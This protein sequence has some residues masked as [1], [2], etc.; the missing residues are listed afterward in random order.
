MDKTKNRL[1][2]IEGQIKGIQKMYD[3]KRGCLDI[4]QQVV[5]VRQALGR[6]GKD[7]LAGEAVACSKNVDKKEEF[8]ELIRKLFDLT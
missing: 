3:E 7:I 8:D 1:N 6:V 5:A 4:V 2:R